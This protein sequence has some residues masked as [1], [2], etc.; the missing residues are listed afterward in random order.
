MKPKIDM[1]HPNENLYFN[2]GRFI[3]KWKDFEIDLYGKIVFKWFPDLSV[4][5]YGKFDDSFDYSIFKPF[6]S[7]LIIEITSTN[8]KFHAKGG[9][10]KLRK[11]EEYNI[12]CYLVPPIDFGEKEINVNH[13]R[14]EIANLRSLYG[15]PVRTEKSALKN[16]I[17]LENSES[18]ITIDKYVNYNVLEQELKESGGYQ[19]LYTGKLE[20]NKK[21]KISF[22]K[23]GLELNTLASFLQF[24]NGRRCS[25]IF[26]YGCTEN[27]DTWKSISPF[28]NDQEKHVFSWVTDQNNNGLSGV[29]KNFWEL[30][31][32]E[33]DRECIITI[34]HW[35]VEANAHSAFIE[36]SLVLIQNAL[37]LL[38]HW[39]IAEKMNYV[40]SSD[41]ENI[42]ASAKTGFLLS[43]YNIDPSIPSEFGALINY[44]KQFNI[45]NGPE[46]FTK[47]RNCIVHP[48]LKKR[49]TLKNLEKN[50]KLEALHLGIWYVEIILLKQLKFNG[51]CKN[52]CKS[53]KLLPDYEIIT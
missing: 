19:L 23:V 6:E 31:Q 24:V 33:S 50:A 42:S 3:L 44:A 26:I 15:I 1:N 37:E 10:S 47:I 2:E 41:A 53:I 11:D 51:E 45:T 14:F 16:R 12:I 46:S 17:I 13:I 4:N 29:W 39:L 43:H 21:K 5:F 8:P 22:E 27:E 36:G 35:Y 7:N 28:L 30:W 49:K 18:R 32:N 48:S 34:L 52:R 40:N 20:L 25:P 38:F 9:I